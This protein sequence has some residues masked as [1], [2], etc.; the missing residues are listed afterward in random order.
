MN[1]KTAL[2]LCMLAGYHDDSK[3]FLRTYVANRISYEA[4][5]ALLENAD[6]MAVGYIHS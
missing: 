1:R 2:G 3:S 4:A 5:P 6:H